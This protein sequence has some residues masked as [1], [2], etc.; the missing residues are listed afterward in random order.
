[1][2]FSITVALGYIVLSE[3]MCPQ[4]PCVQGRTEKRREEKRKK[5]K[6][7]KTIMDRFGFNPNC[8]KVT[9]SSCF[10]TTV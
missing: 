9:V 6:R 5:K 2:E 7:E 1:M 3:T 10:L 4:N 8:S